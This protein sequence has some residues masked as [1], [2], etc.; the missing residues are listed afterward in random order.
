[1][2]PSLTPLL[3]PATTAAPLTPEQLAVLKADIAA[4]PVWGSLPH[5][6]DN[7]YAIAAGYNQPASPDVWV[8]RT[9]LGE[10]EIY[11][12]T[13][14]DGTTWNWQTYMAQTVTERDAWVLIFRPG[15]IN[16]S[17]AQTRAGI[18][19]IFG[20]S[21]GPVV[22]QRTHLAAL[23]RRRA[24]QAE[25]LFA[26]GPGTTASPATMTFEGLLRPADVENA[27]AIP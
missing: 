12:A 27:W 9:S 2:P 13:S 15:Q 17:L 3:G 19:T 5:T 18:N 24:T 25:D 1:V 26:T 8:Y 22:A 4:H 16:P 20:G 23:F 14:T 21:T 11:E 10:K 7:A 6:G